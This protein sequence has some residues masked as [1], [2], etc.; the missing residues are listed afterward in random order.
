ML[1]KARKVGNSFALT[2]PAPIVETMNVY[3][4]LEMEVDYNPYNGVLSYQPDSIREINWEEFIPKSLFS[5]FLATGVYMQSL[6]F[7]TCLGVCA[8]SFSTICDIYQAN[9]KFVPL[10]NVWV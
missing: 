3:D 6:P 10:P 9:Q 7:D 8:H 2:I 4:G 5:F 1:V